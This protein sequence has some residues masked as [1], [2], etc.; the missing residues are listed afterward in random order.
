MKTLL[1]V[2][3]FVYVITLL[4]RLFDL[5]RLINSILKLESFLKADQNS[6]RNK[7]K[8]LNAVLRYYPV[9]S[10]YTSPYDKTLSYGMNMS[11]ASWCCESILDSLLMKRNYAYHDFIYSL[12]PI[13]A[14]KS[15]IVFPVTVLQWLGFR[16]RRY[17]ALILNLAGWMLSYAAH[18][19]EPEIKALLVT[20]FQNFVH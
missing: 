8:K 4:Q 6:R 17:N 5:Y 12:N 16:P 20:I 10:K 15:T 2:L 13:S 14:I 18:L 11:A 9:I 3:A 7:N 1:F 19:F